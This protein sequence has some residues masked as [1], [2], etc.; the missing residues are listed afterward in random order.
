MARQAYALR[1]LGIWLALELIDQG[2]A[3][4]PFPSIRARLREG[5]LEFEPL[6]HVRLLHAQ[7][8]ARRN[9]ARRCRE[10]GLAGVED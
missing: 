9:W 5:E 2:W 8:D 1:V 3:L 7:G 10:L 4:Q 6:A